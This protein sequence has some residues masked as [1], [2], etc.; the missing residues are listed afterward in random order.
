MAWDLGGNWRNELLRM[1]LSK[2]LPL[3]RIHE[4]LPPYPGE[5]PLEIT[6]LR[7]LYNSIEKE[8]PR[9]ANGDRPHFSHL[10]KM[11]VH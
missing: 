11:V 5:A 7:K 6:D 3:S 8:A 1:R 9:L 10:R 4:L 2:T